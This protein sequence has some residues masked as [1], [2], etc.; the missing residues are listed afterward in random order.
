MSSEEIFTIKEKAFFFD[1]Y[2]FYKIYEGSE[3]YKIYGDSKIIT[4]KLNL[5]EI[6][7]ALLREYGETDADKFFNIYYKFVKEFDD[8]VI[9]EA[10]KLKNQLNKR[11]VSMTDCIGYCF[12]KQ[13]GV[14]F[15]TGDNE[16]ENLD[17][18]E[19]VK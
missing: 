9:K 8:K 3:S 10:A 7:L 12:A 5:F 11:N 6:Y 19:F 4:S 15:L 2:A 18:V 17:N 13:L 1:T 16:F 14:K